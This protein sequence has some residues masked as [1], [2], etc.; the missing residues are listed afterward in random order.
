EIVA[1]YWSHDKEG[2]E[3][4]P[5]TGTGSIGLKQHIAVYD[6]V[7]RGMNMIWQ[8]APLA[9]RAAS[10]RMNEAG[11]LVIFE[12]ESRQTAWV[13]TGDAVVAS[14]AASPMQSTITVQ[15]ENAAGMT[16]DP[17]GAETGTQP[18]AATETQQTG[19]GTNPGT[20][21]TGDGVSAPSGSS[22][23]F[24]AVGDDLVHEN[25]W[26]TGV[27]NG[28]DYS[29]LFENIIPMINSVDFACYNQ[30]TMF[31]EESA[32][33][34]GYPMFGSP[35][36]IGEAAI[37]A[38]FDI[39]T[40]STNHS[41][42]KGTYGIETTADFFESHKAEITYLGIYTRDK[43]NE[44]EHEI[45]TVSKNG[46]TFALL[47]FT[48]GLNG[49]PLPADAPYCVDTNLHDLSN[50]S[51]AT[52]AADEERM[53]SY[54]RRAKEISDIVIF[55]PHWGQEYVYEPVNNPHNA[56]DQVYWTN[57]M[58][59]EG[60]DIVVGTH[61]HVVEPVEM[62]VREDGHE[63]LV[64]YSLGNYVSGQNEMPRVVG[65]MATFTVTKKG[66]RCFV[67]AYD[68]LPIVTHQEGGGVTTAYMMDEYTDDLASRHVLGVNVSN[69]RNLF[70]S[71]IDWK[72]Q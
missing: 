43:W 9:T 1:L 14:N 64:Y 66:D 29:Y 40:C 55:F 20:G 27:S 61:P 42:D 19:G 57:V 23:S 2:A 12:P 22:V 34:S 59:E 24:L 36:G 48:Y 17:Q 25:V 13:W 70:R 28:G 26:R 50:Y 45:K 68:M 58:L 30:E 35:I 38:G 65:G 5:L 37:R 51:E 67:S 62:L 16:S 56:Y 11:Y 33:Y 32:G 39:V 71:I 41:L 18:G 44:P 63:M 8:S 3:S 69:M 7:T 60:V 15:T 10:I 31:V 49:I 21:A 72:A 47:N 53:R 52:V 54:I 4:A 46:I 6:G